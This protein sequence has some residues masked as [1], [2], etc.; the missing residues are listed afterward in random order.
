MAT[1][2]PL[3][4]VVATPQ[5]LLDRFRRWAEQAAAVGKLSEYVA[6]MKEAN[7][8]MET[9]PHGWGD[10]LREYPTLNAVKRRGLMAGW[11]L[12][13]YGVDDAARQV[14]VQDLLPAPGSPLADTPSDGP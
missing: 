8:R 7:R 3:R 5:R 1:E 12:V 4:F 11:F 9:T 10:L 2:E 14:V 6:A 13:W